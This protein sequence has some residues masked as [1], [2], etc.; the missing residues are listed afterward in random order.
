MRNKYSCLSGIKIILCTQKN[1][2]T[3]VKAFFK[4]NVEGL[5]DGSAKYR[6]IDAA[7]KEICN[8]DIQ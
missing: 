8:D 1:S 7:K 2:A 6:S 3:S 5:K 4:Q